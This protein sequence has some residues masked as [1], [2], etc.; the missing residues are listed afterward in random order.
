[1][2]AKAKS[3]QSVENRPLTF[4]VDDASRTDVGAL[5]Q[6]EDPSDNTVI[7]CV[8]NPETAAND[9]IVVVVP[10]AD[11]E[12]ITAM[13]FELSLYVLR[14]IVACAGAAKQRWKL[15]ESTAVGQRTLREC[16]DQMPLSEYQAM[17]A[18]VAEASNPPVA[19]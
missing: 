4:I 12:T 15:Q 10:V 14:R 2:P 11:G 17:L 13:Q 7:Q 3:K 8:L 19:Q 18:K 5:I 16:A 6:V 1:M 9:R